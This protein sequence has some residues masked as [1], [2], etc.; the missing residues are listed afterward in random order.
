MFVIRDRFVKNKNSRLVRESLSLCNKVLSYVSLRFEFDLLG[1][2]L[3]VRSLLM[4]GSEGFPRAMFSIR[5]LIGLFFMH[6]SLCERS[7]FLLF[8]FGLEFDHH[9]C[10]HF[11]MLCTNEEHEKVAS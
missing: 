8:V 11:G 5:G 10:S 6:Q 2:E 7:S 3:L 1:A 9:G 4:K